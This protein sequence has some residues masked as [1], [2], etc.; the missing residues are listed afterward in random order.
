VFLSGGAANV[1]S[2]NDDVILSLN[3]TAVHDDAEAI[4][5]RFSIA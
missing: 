2:G 3:W 4:T 1:N 5:A